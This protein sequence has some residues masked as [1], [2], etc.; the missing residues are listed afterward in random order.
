MVNLL[1]IDNA[2]KTC[3]NKKA[4]GGVAVIVENSVP[5][6]FVKLETTLQAVAVNLSLN[7]CVTLC[8]VYF[9]P[10]SQIRKLIS[11][12]LTIL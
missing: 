10:S 1:I 3:F 6:H 4:S 9:P 7:K 11:R 2:N 12:N 5:H 8:S